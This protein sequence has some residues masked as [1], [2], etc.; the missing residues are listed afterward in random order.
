MHC[1]E[2]CQHVGTTVNAT[3]SRASFAVWLGAFSAE[4]GRCNSRGVRRAGVTS[5]E[6]PS[7]TNL[8]IMIAIAG[9]YFGQDEELAAGF[10]M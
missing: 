3:T 10:D 7:L 1:N 9:G 2:R 5:R 6:D 8:N 4:V